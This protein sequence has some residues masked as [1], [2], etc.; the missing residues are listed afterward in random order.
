M[1]S[2]LAGTSVSR[3]MLSASRPADCSAGSRRDSTTPFVVIPTERIP[4]TDFRPAVQG[5][6]GG[7]SN[8][9]PGDRLTVRGIDRLR[10]GQTG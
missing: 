2:N 5:E 8:A 4:G 7:G 3:L 10:R 6:G 9:V 1:S